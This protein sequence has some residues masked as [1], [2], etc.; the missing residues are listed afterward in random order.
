MAQ[1]TVNADWN[2]LG[3]VAATAMSIGSYPVL[4]IVN[5]SEF[6]MLQYIGGIVEAR[7]TVYAEGTE[8]WLESDDP[9]LEL[10][11]TL[12]DAEVTTGTSV[13]GIITNGGFMQWAATENWDATHHGSRL[14]FW[15]NAPGAGGLVNAFE[16][17]ST[18]A[19]FSSNISF[20]NVTPAAWSGVSAAQSH[21]TSWFDDAAGGGGWTINGYYDGAWKRIAADEAAGWYSTNGYIYFRTAVDAAAD[22]AITWVETLR[23]DPAGRV[24]L[25][26]NPSAWN[27]I[28]SPIEMSTGAGC[29][30]GGTDR[31]VGMVSNLYYD[32]DG[33][34]RHRVTGAGAVLTIDQLGQATFYHSASTSAGFGA[35]LTTKFAVTATGIN[36]AAIGATT[37]STVAA[38]TLTANTSLGFASGAGGAVTQT[39][40]KT[41]A[42]PALN[43]S[44]GQITMHNASMAAGAVVTFTMPNSV[45]TAVDMVL[46]S[47][48]SGGTIGPYLINGRVSAAGTLSFSVRNT[49]AGALA[50]AIVI[51]FALIKAVVA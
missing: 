51:K 18:Y 21:R 10:Y 20:G 2:I 30:Y 15:V 25:G 5:P 9:S 34:W 49:S 12:L 39:T 24:G 1:I 46:T 27:A 41:T 43:K 4:P 42:A 28:I 48:H 50:E 35:T 8:L 23:I 32:T 3:A 29:V 40:S 26:V 17:R 11:S 44:T 6:G 31:S 36:N 37:P 22:S 45:A 16:L 19:K 14:R 13:G 33:I 38:T 47:H 7:S